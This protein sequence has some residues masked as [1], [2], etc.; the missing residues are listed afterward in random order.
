MGRGA[1]KKSEGRGSSVPLGGPAGLVGH[2][3]LGNIQLY[4]WT[5]CILFPYCRPLLRSTATVANTC[6]E[7]SSSI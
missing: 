5:F 4:F 7:I 3:M 6:D 2:V 1:E